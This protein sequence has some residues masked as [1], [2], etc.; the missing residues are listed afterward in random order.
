MKFK[1]YLVNCLVLTAVLTSFLLSSCNKQ[2]AKDTTGFELVDQEYFRERG[3]DVLVYNNNAIGTFN[4]E[5]STG[6]E[7]VHCGMRTLQGGTVRLTSTPEQWDLMP[8]LVKRTCNKEE[9]NIEVEMKYPKYSFEFKMKVASEGNS[10]KVDVILDKPLPAFL[11]GKAGL[12]IELLPSQYWDKTYL[13]DGNVNRFPRYAVGETKALPDS[14]KVAQYKGFRTDD[15]R[16]T[17]TYVSPMPFAEGNELTIA[18]ETPERMIKVSSKEASLKLYDGRLLAQNGWYV[19]RSEI[20]SGR[21]GNVISWTIT[22]NQIKDWVRKPNIGYSQVGYLPSQSK[23]AVIELDSVDIVKPSAKVWRINPDGTHAVAF[24]G[25]TKEWGMYY[26]Y[27]YVQFDFSAV[28]QPGTYYIEYGDVKTANFII[29][30]QV[31][32]NIA[33]ATQDVWVPIHMNHMAVNEGYRMWHGEPFKEGYLQAPESDH[34]DLHSQKSNTDSPFKPYQLIPGLNVGGFF[35]AGD[36]DIE[37]GSIVSVVSN[38]VRA[39]EQFQPQRDQTFVS[40]QQRYVDLHRPDGTPDILQYIKHGTLNL[41]AQVEAIG[42]PA[43]T[44]SNSVLDNYHHLGDA[45]SITDG[46][47]YDPSLRPYEKSADGKRSGTPDD[48]WAFTNRN[49]ML[50][51]R[52]S[53]ALAASAR[54][55]KGYD[56]ALASKALA[57]AEKL[58]SESI[59]RMKNDTTRSKNRGQHDD[60]FSRGQSQIPVNIQLYATTHKEQYREAF[61]ASLWKVLDRNVRLAFQPALDAIP[62]MDDAYKEKLKPYVKQ[63]FDSIFVKKDDQNPY[64]VPIG[65]GTWA[66]S[67]AVAEFGT[68]VCLASHYYPDIVSSEQAFRAADFLFGCHPYHNLSLVAT[69]GATQPKKVFY[70]NNRA[71]FAAI[72]GNMAPGVLLH[73]PNHFENMDDWPFFWGENEGTIASNTS[74]IIFGYALRQYAVADALAKAKNKK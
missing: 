47:H 70:G 55:L 11:E 19:L 46:L 52:T 49:P 1:T 29:G 60:R 33:Y 6:I 53:A 2:E 65:K 34:F 61:L 17:G 21:T 15:N 67:S 9:G 44:L 64:G 45:A 48:M 28:E 8:D 62:F 56:D 35:D 27:N 18:P 41:V 22:P 69:I 58:L 59:E 16:G 14:T 38:L 51:L 30:D 26:K 74:Y 57:Q 13:M 71:D 10:I 42:H 7:I 50:D 32:D 39:W 73:K 37:T 24:A 20:P 66:S 23:V 4:D 43:S 72:P 40:W 3:V 54:A 12:N 68:S 63:Y 25:N 5:K 31:Y 36:F